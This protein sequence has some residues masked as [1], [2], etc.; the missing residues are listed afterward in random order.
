[1]LG[2]DLLPVLGGEVFFIQTFGTL[3]DMSGTQL[4]DFELF[5]LLDSVTVPYRYSA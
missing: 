3:H 5:W 4:D 2:P 1:M